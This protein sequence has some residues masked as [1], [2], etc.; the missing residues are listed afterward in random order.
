MLL[1]SLLSLAEVQPGSSGKSIL[2]SLSSSIELEHSGLAPWSIQFVFNWNFVP[3]HEV[4]PSQEK[5]IISD[6]IP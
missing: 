2:P 3:P 5:W 1:V 4:S 6:I